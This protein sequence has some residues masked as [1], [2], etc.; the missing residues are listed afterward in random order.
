MG[1]AGGGRHLFLAQYS[2]TLTLFSQGANKH[3]VKPRV[4]NFGDG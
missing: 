2:K 3:R 1:V 4:K